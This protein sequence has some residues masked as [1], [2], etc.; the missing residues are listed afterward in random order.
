MPIDE[1]HRNAIAEK[2][3]L[4]TPQDLNFD[5]VD[6][7]CY[8]NKQKEPLSSGDNCKVRTVVSSRTLLHYYITNF[9]FILTRI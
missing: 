3:H 6:P 2:L 7:F 5:F 9:T 1:D 4:H 8:K